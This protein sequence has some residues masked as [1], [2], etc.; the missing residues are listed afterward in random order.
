M[1]QGEWTQIPP[2]PGVCFMA[3]HV[4]VM[5]GGEAEQGDKEGPCEHWAP[6]L[7]T[8]ARR[9][10][11]AEE[12]QGAILHTSQGPRP[13]LG[14]ATQ[15]GLALGGENSQPAQRH[16]LL[17]QRGLTGP[18]SE[19]TTQQEGSKLGRKTKLWK[20]QKQGLP[21]EGGWGIW[22]QTRPLVWLDLLAWAHSHRSTKQ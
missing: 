3:A 14:L 12:A 7:G 19:G 13:V 8:K 9:T 18:H 10:H 21:R 22:V 6:R 11:Q 20:G 5:Q 1:P 17:G 4:M 16:C 2:H 15:Q